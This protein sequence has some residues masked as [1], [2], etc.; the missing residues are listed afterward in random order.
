MKTALLLLAL[1][2]STGRPTIPFEDDFKAVAGHRWLDRAAQVKAE[3][4]FKLNAQSYRKLPDGTK[5]PLAKGISQFTDPTWEWAQKVGWVA[6]G[7]S[8][9]DPQAAIN[10]NHNYMLW[11]E[12]RVGGEWAPALGGYNAGLGSVRKAQRLADSIGLP[13]KDAWLQAL[14]R[15]TGAEHS[16]ET[17][18]YIARIR[19]FRAEFRALFGE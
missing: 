19:R 10:A 9:F 15:I 18:D 16:K 3:S 12:A 17:R 4:G 14:P 8:P 13:G 11:L 2:T 1:S 5:V 7:A 6:R